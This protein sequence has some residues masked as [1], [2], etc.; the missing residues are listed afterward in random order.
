[1][2]RGAALRP[3]RMA[4]CRVALLAAWLVPT[5]AGSA[6]LIGLVR[7]QSAAQIVATSTHQLEL[8]VGGPVRVEGLQ[9]LPDGSLLLSGVHCYERT[10]GTLLASAPQLAL[11]RGERS[12]NLSADLLVLH[13]PQLLQLAGNCLS[14]GLPGTDE[15]QQAPL[16]WQLRAHRVLWQSGAFQQTFQ[17]ATFSIT[18]SP[19][20]P[21]HST[22][23]VVAYAAE[24]DP[25]QPPLTLEWVRRSDDAATASAGRLSTGAASLACRGLEALWPAARRLGPACEFRGELSW[26]TA[27]DLREAALRG[28]L[29][30]LDLDTLISE[31]FPHRFS[32]TARVHLQR[33]AI[34][35]GRLVEL[36]GR[37]EAGPGVLSAS[38]L[39]AAAQ[40]LSVSVP[41]NLVDSPPTA[42]IPFRRLA[43]RFQ[44]D[45]WQLRLHGVADSSGPPVLLTDD[46]GPL[47]TAPPDHAAPAIALVRM[48]VP[49]SEH[50][51]PATR[52]T[53]MLVRLLPLPDAPLAATARHTPTR[54][55]PTEQD[56]Q[57]TSAS[58]PLRPPGL[59]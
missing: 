31:Q 19:P 36:Q 33:A 27:A 47:A 39:A 21:Q 28:E 55:A 51:V 54:L 23:K 59:R 10:T 38:L 25:S 2:L 12:W 6:V 56:P 45:A 34:Q 16:D 3:C 58:P 42:A 26:N 22:L 49:P 7:W 48:L 43:C 9:V 11:H 4:P 32:G 29:V 46:G 40:H 50:Q 30:G 17:Q 37:I 35:Q 1:M 20:Q 24:Q 5:V 8:L 18:R 44:L 13:G 14:P 53:A 41:K 15:R 57:R 52:Q